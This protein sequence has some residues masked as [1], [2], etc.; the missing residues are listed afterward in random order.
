MIWYS[1]MQKLTH[2]ANNSIVKV[3]YVYRQAFFSIIFMLF[4][5]NSVKKVLLNAKGPIN[6][7][8]QTIEKL[9]GSFFCYINALH[10]MKKI[11]LYKIM[12]ELKLII[13]FCML[14][15]VNLSLNKQLRQHRADP[16]LA[17]IPAPNLYCS[18]RQTDY[19]SPVRVNS[20]A[21]LVVTT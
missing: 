5:L 16:A 21:S 10:F 1:Y 11:L 19:S 8:W 3:K 6:V 18:P 20:T 15:S 13:L 2:T 7:K 17:S 9:S 14:S 12:K 4:I